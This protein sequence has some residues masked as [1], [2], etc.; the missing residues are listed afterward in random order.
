MLVRE[1]NQPDSTQDLDARV[2][3]LG[4]QPMRAG[5]RY[6]LH[7]TSREAKAVVKEVVYKLDINTPAPHRRRPGHRD[8]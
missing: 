5:T 4:D 1:N 7:H 8:E 3:W 6:E 2:C